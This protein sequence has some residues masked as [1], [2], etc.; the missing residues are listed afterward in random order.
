MRAPPHP[1]YPGQK[2]FAFTILDDTDDSTVENVGPIYDLLHELGMRTTK[3]VWPVACPEGSKW[4]FAGETLADDA[5]RQ[6]AHELARRG[7]ELTWHGATMESSTRDRTEHALEVFLREF[8]FY[9][10]I[11][12]NH[13]Q[14]RE[15]IYWGR[16]RYRN[17]LLRGVHRLTRLRRGDFGGE[18]EGS[19]YFWGDICR[20]HFGYV[21]GF[22]FHEINTLRADPALLYRL[23]STPY[24]NCWF[25]TSDATDV[26]EFTRLVSPRAVDRLR[27]Q[28]GLCILSTH[29]GKGFVRGG[30]IDPAVE[31][32]LRYTASL[33]GWFVPVSEILDWFAARRPVVERPLARQL[34]IE[35]RHV[36][37]RVHAALS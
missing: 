10:R 2:E 16:K 24:V 28:R 9:P 15:N 27:Q 19:P 22:T 37:D 13:G 14:N 21:R 4:Y 20:R 11:H 17:P 32:V 31:E 26:G 3:T 25:S 6:F 7:F 1:S 5:Y 36:A 30:R 34:T 12:V 18:V 35:L 29:L 23:R 33:P 8:G